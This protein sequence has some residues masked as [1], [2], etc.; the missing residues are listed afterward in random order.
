MKYSEK[1]QKCLDKKDT[2]EIITEGQK[3]TGT[4][5]EVGEDYV[6]IVCAVEREIIETITI[7]EGEHKGKTEEQ[8]HI[9]VIELETILCIADIHAVSRI[10]K[11]KLK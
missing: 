9:Q 5:S 1:L 2:V 4:L 11:K 10:I 6:A 3:V 7:T 8:K